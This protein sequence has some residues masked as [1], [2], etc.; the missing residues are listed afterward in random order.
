[1]RLKTNKKKIFISSTYLD[2]IPHRKQVWKV[3]KDYDV[4]IKGM[5]SF[6]ARSSSPL[7]TCL[8]ELEECEIYIGIISMR[9]GSIDN[10]TEKSFTQLEYERAKDLGLDIY[11]YLIDEYKG[12]VETGSIDFEDKYFKLTSFKRILK[13]E[14]TVDF[15]INEIDLGRKIHDKLKEILPEKKELIFR[16]KELEAKIHRY[17]F[18]KDK[19]VIFVSYY[20]GK[21]FEILTA[22]SDEDYGIMMP[23]SVDEGV[24]IKNTDESYERFDFRFKNRRGYNVTIEQ[25]NYNSCLFDNYDRILRNL[26]QSN[27][28]LKVIISTLNSINPDIKGFPEW[29]ET[30]I[31]ILDNY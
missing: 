19:I 30:V 25:I 18:E 21:P 20:N 26:L 28:S 5:E 8:K 17:N 7:E 1:M 29:R 6:G 22:V 12:Q 27:V 31:R 2:L 4:E 13:K 16:P 24:V 14:R 15:F 11:I 10:D 3:L 9:Y 23:S